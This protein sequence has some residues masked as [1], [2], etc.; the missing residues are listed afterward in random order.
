MSLNTVAQ[1]RYTYSSEFNI[2]SDNDAY[3]LRLKD[4]YYT[5]GIMLGW[6]YVAKQKSG[7]EDRRSVKKISYYRIGQKIFNSDNWRSYLPE[8]IDR[9]F[10]GYL[11]AEKG[12]RVF[13]KSGDVLEFSLNAGTVGPSSYGQEIQSMLHRWLGFATIR[14]WA[15]QVKNEAGLNFMAK[16]D[17]QVAGNPMKSLFQ[18]RATAE[19]SVG[20][21]FTYA[22]A[23]G[24]FL[25]GEMETADRSAQFRSRIGN[26]KKQRRSELYGFFQPQVLFQAYNA[27]VEGGFFGKDKGPITSEL[28]RFTFMHEWGVVFAQDRWTSSLSF[29]RKQKEAATMRHNE[30]FGSIRIAYR[31]GRKNNSNENGFTTDDNADPK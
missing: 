12:Y 31:I 15:Y 30:M 20:N 24:I 1:D 8:Q 17:K 7:N 11:F 5:N 10:A 2:E 25:F 22:K 13:Y 3:L 6:T 14:G 18:L 26:E 21:L 9:P 29:T 16:Y 28:N 4:G 23:G 19:G 27:T